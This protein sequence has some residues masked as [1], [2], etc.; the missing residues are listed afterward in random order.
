MIKAFFIKAFSLIVA[1]SMMLV[2]GVSHTEEYDVRDP[3]SCVL[4]F[5]VLS[6][7]H[8]EG[9][10]FTR[11]KVFEHSLQNV[12]KNKSGNDA[13]A[14]LG[15]NTMNG[16]NV[17]SMLF[18]GT[19]S[20][21]LKGEN[22]IPVMGNHD[23][24]NGNGDYRKLRSR[25]LDYASASFG[26][27]I[28]REYYFRVID[29]C[30]FIVLAMESHLVYDMYIS[31]AQYEWLEDLLSKADGT[32]RPTFIFS[33]YPSTYT[34]DEN[35]NDTERLYDILSDFGQ[36]NDLFYFSG[37]THVPISRW[38]FRDR[39]NFTE[40][41]LPR[42]TEL[43]G[44]DDDEIISITGDAVEVEVYGTEVLVRARNFYTGEWKISGGE[45]L[46][47]TYSLKNPIG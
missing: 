44:T 41:M 21:M 16:Q 11:Y 32:G 28:E 42:L 34:V 30:Y 15:D 33:H 7:V 35:E 5:S 46:E 31:D 27:D 38:S 1:L 9:N 26:K 8:I 3:E 19:A 13:I 18:Y 25:F 4:N 12:K 43:G 23:I 47:E 10:N 36:E 24:G 14:F 2:C 37:H 22:V 20:T 29:G 45:P 17:E 40:I 39:D 6:D